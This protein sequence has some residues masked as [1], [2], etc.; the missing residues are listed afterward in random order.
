[1][2]NFENDVNGKFVQS[3]AT[4]KCMENKSNITLFILINFQMT[5][6]AW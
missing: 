5:S 6:W 1:M 2:K 3:S 4:L